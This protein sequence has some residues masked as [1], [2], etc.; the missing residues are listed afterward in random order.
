VHDMF[1]SLTCD[2]SSDVLSHSAPQELQEVQLDSLC[3]ESSQGAE[4]ER[5]HSQL[6]LERTHLQQVSSA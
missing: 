1:S 4:L 3:A 6:D 5:L 2:K